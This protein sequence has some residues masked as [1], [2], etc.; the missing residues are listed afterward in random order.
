MATPSVSNGTRNFY[1]TGIPDTNSFYSVEI[2]AEK[3]GYM[4]QFKIWKL[5]ASPDFVL[6]KEGSDILNCIHTGDVLRMTYYSDDYDAYKTALYSPAIHYPMKDKSETYSVEGDN[7]DLRHY[8][9]RLRRKSRCFSRC[10]H[11]LHNAVKLFVFAYNQRQLFK[12]RFPKYNP[13]LMYF[14]TP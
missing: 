1:D 13:P 10:E 2:Q 12:Q 8:L 5:P 6:V 4:Y 11:A 7:S 9:A 14:A 3:A